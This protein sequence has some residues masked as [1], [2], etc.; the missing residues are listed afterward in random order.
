MNKTLL[1]NIAQIVS[2]PVAAG[3]VSAGIFI[4]INIYANTQLQHQAV[5]GCFEVAK[6]AKS[7]SGQSD[8][9]NW[10]VSEATINL[11]VVRECL[12]QKGK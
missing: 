5:Q 6:G 7:T 2:L 8:T 10:S 4:S 3:I 9:S 1:I 11:D 12:A